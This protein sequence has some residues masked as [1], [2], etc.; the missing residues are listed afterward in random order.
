[1]DKSW[2][3]A[4]RALF[5]DRLQNP[6]Y[7]ATMGFHRYED[8]RRLIRFDDKRTR[9]LS[10]GIRHT[11]RNITM[12]NLFTSIPLAE[13]LLRLWGLFARTSQTFHLS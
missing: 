3:V 6:M 11:G 10:S 9:A 7:K 13:K 2:D 1:G 5:L 4:L 8:I 12:D